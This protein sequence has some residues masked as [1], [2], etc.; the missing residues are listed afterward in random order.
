MSLEE[1]INLTDPLTP[2]NTSISHMRHCIGF[3][4]DVLVSLRS[5]DMGIPWRII[6]RSSRLLFMED[7][8]IMASIYT[9]ILTLMI[10]IV[11]IVLLSLGSKLSPMV[12]LKNIEVTTHLLSTKTN[13]S[14]SVESTRE[15][16]LAITLISVL[17]IKTK[18]EEQCTRLKSRHKSPNQFLRNR[19][20]SE[21]KWKRRTW[22]KNRKIYYSY[23]SLEGNLSNK[24][25]LIIYLESVG[26]KRKKVFLLKSF[27][28]DLSIRRR[29][30]ISQLQEKKIEINNNKKNK[31]IKL[32][33]Q[34]LKELK[35]CVLCLRI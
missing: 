15:D 2:L 18:L 30:L 26:L 32:N 8:T 24:I 31:L 20:E 3:I 13:F 16:S 19:K 14:Y 11:W 35:H 9:V 1:R 33:S 12:R 7:K 23:K 25:S 6:K 29:I 5:R 17:W 28:K 10:F 4:H 22:I 21:R 34:Y 27:K